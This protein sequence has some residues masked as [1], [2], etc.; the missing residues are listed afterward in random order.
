M[1]EFFCRVATP[2]GDIFERSYVAADEPALRRDLEKQELMILNVRRR[3]PMMQ[4]FAR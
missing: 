3:N 4:E 2:A 1:P